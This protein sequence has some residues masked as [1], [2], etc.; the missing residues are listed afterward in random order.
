MP[1]NSPTYCFTN[2]FYHNLIHEFVGDIMYPMATTKLD[3]ETICRTLDSFVEHH[4]EE[5][6]CEEFCC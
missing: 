4:L 6:A 3:F 2:T 1:E 5:S